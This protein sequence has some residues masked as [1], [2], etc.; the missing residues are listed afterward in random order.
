MSAMKE[1][2]SRL[3]EVLHAEPLAEVV[4]GTSKIGAFDAGALQVAMMVAALDGEV[5]PEELA[6]FEKLARDCRGYTEESAAAV[7]DRGLR[8]AGYVMLQARRLGEN[9]LA[10]L[11]VA[12]AEK[13]LPSGLIEAA[14]ED[15]RRAVAMWVAMGM[16]DGDFSGIERK[17]V[18]AFRA[19]FS[20]RIGAEIDRA[21]EHMKTASPQF[22]VAYGQGRR[23]G[24]DTKPIASDF[25]SRAELVLATLRSG[26][27]LGTAAKELMELI[28]RG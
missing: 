8:L 18:E 9:E 13:A 21:A 16:S 14:S 7:F 24:V 25:I 22:A 1:F 19:R 2:L 26:D 11:F 3:V 23:P 17:C 28:A 15:V 12:E 4:S 5:S 6:A 10:E 20:A 27:P